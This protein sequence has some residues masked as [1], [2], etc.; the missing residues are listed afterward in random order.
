MLGEMGVNHVG[1]KRLNRGQR[2]SLICLDQT[3]ITDDVSRENG[4][5][6]PL[7]LDYPMATSLAEH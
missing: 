7:S 6:P 5:Q 3:R 1:P 4:D 2:P